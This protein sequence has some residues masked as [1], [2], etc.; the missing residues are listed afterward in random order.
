MFGNKKNK[1]RF[2][3]NINKEQAEEEYK[4]YLNQPPEVLDNLKKCK[5]FMAVFIPLGILLS[6]VVLGFCFE[7]KSLIGSVVT[8]GNCLFSGAINFFISKRFINN[9]NRKLRLVPLIC[10]CVGWVIGIV[11][12]QPIILI[13]LNVA[14]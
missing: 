6:L 13:I 12:V 2:R 10:L 5:I 11:C 1:E 4:E 9:R 3:L 7:F 8:L 14:G